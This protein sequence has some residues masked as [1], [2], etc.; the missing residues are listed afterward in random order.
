MSVGTALGCFSSLISMPGTPANNIPGG[1]SISGQPA[2]PKKD[3]G[4]DK[5]PWIPV[6]FRY[7]CPSITFSLLTSLGCGAGDHCSDAEQ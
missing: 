7:I 1:L 2:P 4:N 5:L 6:R 3:E